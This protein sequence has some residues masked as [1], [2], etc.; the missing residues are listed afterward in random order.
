MGNNI[1]SIWLQM[2]PILY[3]G[4]GVFLL[5][6]I[7]PKGDLY[8]NYNR[9]RK[10]LGI[11]LLVFGVYIGSLGVLKNQLS[12][13][14]LSSTYNLSVYFGAAHI[15]CLFF[16]TL[17][18]KEI[19]F[20]NEIRKISIRWI[21]FTS[22]L[23]INYLYVPISIQNVIIIICSLLL[24]AELCFILFKFFKVYTLA[25]NKVD[26]LYSENVSVFIKWMKYSL[27]ML[28]VIGVFGFTHSYYPPIVNMIYGIVSVIFFTYMLISFQNYM[29]TLSEIHLVFEQE[30]QDDTVEIKP[31]DK[32]SLIA[33]RELKE[34][35]D[36]WITSKGFTKVGVT[37]E[38]LSRTLRSNRT[39][40]SAYIR[41]NYN[42]SYRDWIT[43]LRIKY[44]KE[45]FESD[46]SILVSQVAE[47]VGYNRSSYT[48]A[49][50]KECGVSP[51][52]WREQ[53][54]LD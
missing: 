38:D 40:V 31:L 11:L 42:M 9:A 45:L 17:L 50:I 15:S 13:I 18:R 20:G 36:D 14:I 35:M 1:Y 41:E 53:K 48:K 2:A 52:T 30:Q 39:Y 33:K 21:L 44:S 7:T 16:Y 46:S 32:I 54:K 6:T 49:F 28:I 26:D 3:F 43:T 4:F 10:I 22:I 23:L 51:A 37:I 47:M 25:K 12:D 27:Y 34:S 24:F 29:V 8:K 5:G 19:S